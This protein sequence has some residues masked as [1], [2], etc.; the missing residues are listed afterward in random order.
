MNEELLDKIRLISP[1]TLLRKALDDILR[2]NMGALILMINEPEEYPEI[3]QG[4]FDIN[5]PF[6]PEYLYELSKMDG[7]I[8]ISE[9]TKTIFKANVHLIPDP[10]IETKETG[11]RHRTAERLAKQLDKVVIAVSRR[12]NVI[13]LYYKDFRY[14]VND[15]SFVVSRVNQAISALE[16]YRKSFDRFILELDVMELENRTTLAD[17]V[18]AMEKGLMVLKIDLEVKPYLVELGEEGRLA[19]MQISELTEN[20]EDL[21]KLL[22]MDYSS[23][24]LDSKEASEILGLMLKGEMDL[25]GI[26]KLLGYE[27]QA[28]SQMDD[29]T[30]SARGYRLLKYAAKIPMSVSR[31]VVER[32]KNIFSIS[33]AS[34]A[35]LKSVEGI[36]DKRAK[37]ILESINSL[38]MR[39]TAYTEEEIQ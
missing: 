4:G 27:V 8:V 11:T 31:N 9:D 2:A 24:H 32:F 18:R 15:T 35:E 7:A 29:I 17:A 3:I 37:A 38:R 6:Q 30:I 12:R 10:S 33:R 5:V 22:I 1:G 23:E 19:T 20:A 28:P 34:L 14:V 21:M 25:I 26:A 16:K 13:T 39:K 36:G